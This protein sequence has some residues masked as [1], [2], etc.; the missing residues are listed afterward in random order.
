ML[1]RKKDIWWQH[2]QCSRHHLG[3]S[4]NEGEK[5]NKI[6][7]PFQHLDGTILSGLSCHYLYQLVCTDEVS[8]LNTN[9]AVNPNSNFLICARTNRFFNDYLS[10]IGYMRNWLKKVLNEYI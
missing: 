2:H 5:H 7:P 8:W 10:F 4:T 1:D 9:S 6:P 3:R